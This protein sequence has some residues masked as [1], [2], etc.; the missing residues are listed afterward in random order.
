MSLK[1][2]VTSY[3]D[4]N[5]LTCH[6]HKADCSKQVMLGC[7]NC[8]CKM[9]ATLTH[10]KRFWQVPNYRYAKSKY[11]IDHTCVCCII[12]AK[13]DSCENRCKNIDYENKRVR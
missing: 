13:L 10:C 4:R 9:C 6:R 7:P 5:T 1:D 8:Q 11:N 3:L 12:C 2:L